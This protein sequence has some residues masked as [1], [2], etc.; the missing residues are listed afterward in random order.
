MRRNAA[1]FSLLRPKSLLTSGR[2]GEREV[3]DME[4]LYFVCPNTGRNIDAGIETDLETLLRIKTQTIEIE[5]P[6][7]RERHEWR[8]AD[9]R[10]ATAA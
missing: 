5:C 6:I 4:H 10:L 1:S 8:V 7:C 9:A 3:L 2:T